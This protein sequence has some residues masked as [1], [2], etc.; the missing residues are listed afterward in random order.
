M[1]RVR[2]VRPMAGGSALALVLWLTAGASAQPA[3]GPGGGA[4]G[5]PPP[6]P[7]TDPVPPPLPKQPAA[8]YFVEERGQPAGP[9]SL[10]ELRR[11]IE[12]RAIG[13]TTLVWKAGT[14]DWVKAEE[15]PELRDML[16]ASPPPVPKDAD[17][18][19]VLI[20]S[21]EASGRSPAGFGWSSSIQYLP[22]GTF[23]GFTTT[24]YGGSQAA[25]PMVG[26]WSVQ[27]AG[28]GRLAL[29]LDVQ[30][31]LPQTAVLKIIDENTLLNEAQ[32]YYARR[33]GR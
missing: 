21:W 23:S 33:A 3:G 13:R 6:L 11:R 18:R 20:G 5:E 24:S 16:A 27:P 22:D 10:E 8:R 32:G 1:T 25:V 26:R 2:A 12:T 19:N 30:G 7:R 17:L 28:E 14:P 29:T 9:L 4:G 31:Q 15:L